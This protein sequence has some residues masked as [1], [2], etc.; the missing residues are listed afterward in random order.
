MKFLRKILD[1]IFYI[2]HPI[3]KSDSVQLFLRKYIALPYS[4][5]EHLNF[6]GVVSFFVDSKELFMKSYNTPIEIT[7]FWRGV[8]SGREGL[9]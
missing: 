8:F 1:T 4:M 3:F 7:V 2:I 9:S 5:T 6:T